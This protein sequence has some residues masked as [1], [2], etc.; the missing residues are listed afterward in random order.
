MHRPVQITPSRVIR[1]HTHH[2]LTGWF[3]VGGCG[4]FFLGIG[5]LSGIVG[6]RPKSSTEPN[7]PD[8][9]QPT[10]VRSDISSEAPVILTK[11]AVV[12]TK[13]PTRV[14]TK[15][16]TQATTVP[17]LE[18]SRVCSDAPPTRLYVGAKA[19]VS[20]VPPD[21]NRVRSEPQAFTQNVLGKIYPGD[22]VTVVEG[23]AC[24]NGWVWWRIKSQ[25]G[26]LIGWTAEGDENNYW[27]IPRP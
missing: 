20:Y 4:L 15:I 6:L 23:P 12:P 27:L 24:N 25:K 18:N 17:T 5:L 11:V 8:T 16:P 14:T 13:V 26:N 2:I 9:I 7:T 21:P 10:I 3:V 22:E 1:N 19:Y